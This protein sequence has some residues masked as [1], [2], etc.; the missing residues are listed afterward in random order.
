MINT[1][2]FGQVFLLLLLTMTGSSYYMEKYKMLE[3]IMSYKFPRN[4]LW[5]FFGI[6]SATGIAVVFYQPFLGLLFIYLSVLLLAAIKTGNQYQWML[7]QI[8]IGY[9]FIVVYI[10][11]WTFE[12]MSWWD[13]VR[14]LF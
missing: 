14:L 5:A 9:L 3:K 11:I 2:S 10:M 8:K 12:E 13:R 1:S 4:L 7:G 6:N